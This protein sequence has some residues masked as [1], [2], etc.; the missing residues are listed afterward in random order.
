MLQTLVRNTEVSLSAQHGGRIKDGG[1]FV[2]YK[3]SCA[4]FLIRIKEHYVAVP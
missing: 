4:I 3:Q 1:I 2:A